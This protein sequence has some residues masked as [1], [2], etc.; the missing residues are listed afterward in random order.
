[1]A[2]S[3]VFSEPVLGQRTSPYLQS[4]L[5]LLGCEQVFGK[6]PAIVESLL[7]I[8]VNPSQVY[9]TCQKAAYIVDEAVLDE[10]SAVLNEQLLAVEQT[11]YGMVDG[12]MLPTEEGWQEVKV[13]RV[14]GAQPTQASPQESR[15]WDVKPSE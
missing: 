3:H 9:R 13:G 14:F 5:V 12:S 1:M 4:K 10:P 7:G 15:K 8:Q 11:V 6:V 2:K